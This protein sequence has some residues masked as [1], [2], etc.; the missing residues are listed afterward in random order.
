[1]SGRLPPEVALPEGTVHP[2]GEGRIE[3][4]QPSQRRLT[5]PNAITVLRLFGSGALFWLACAGREREFLILFAALL[6]TDWLDGRLAVILRQQSILGARLDSLADAF[7]YAALLF[8]LLV[9]EPDFAADESLLLSVMMASY[10]VSL[11][12]ALARFGRLPAYHTWAAKSCWLF[13]S[14][15][16]FSILLDGPPWLPRLAILLVILTN[17]EETLITLRLRQWRA[18]VPSIFH[19]ARNRGAGP[20]GCGAG[21]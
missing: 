16:A 9:L 2:D 7:M 5:I 11:V 1:M 6:V 15:G 3:R 4:G 8:G 18:N 20:S 17:V 14:A 12:A 19:L 10:A 21:R 13:V